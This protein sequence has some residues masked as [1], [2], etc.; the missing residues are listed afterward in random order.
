MARKKNYWT[1]V[2]DKYYIQWATGTETEKV[3]A[4]NYL[5]GRLNYM[6]SNILY[7]Y[8]PSALGDWQREKEYIEDAVNHLLVNGN[9]DADRKAT[10]FSYC[11]A[12]IKHYLYDRIVFRPSYKNQ[13]MTDRNYDTSS[14]ENDYIFNDYNE[15]PDFEEFDL[16]ERQALLDRIIMI[17][18]EK[19]VSWQ[20]KI[21]KSLQA[22]DEEIKLIVLFKRRI[23]VLDAIMEY[24]NEY[25]I[26]TT[27]E[28]G[29]L[30]DYV[31]NNVEGNMAQIKKYMLESVG[32]FSDTRKIDNTKVKDRSET[33]WGGYIQNDTAPADKEKRVGRHGA[34]KSGHLKK[35]NIFEDLKKYQ[36]F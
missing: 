24:F 27:V 28:I 10:I 35:Y 16:T 36:Y 3:R 1:E 13:I 19:K 7:K 8:Y 6:T 20:S 2:E 30:S 17:L 12:I 32:C 9:Y 14:P 31:I 15:A 5:I 18:T 25:F 23:A 29:D 4:Y 33:S 26:T 34:L 21:D 11:S 22:N